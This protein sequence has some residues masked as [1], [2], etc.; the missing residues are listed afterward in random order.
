M[1]LERRSA[2]GRRSIAGRRGNV[3][4]I[5]LLIVVLLSLIGASLLSFG[6]NEHLI[7]FREKDSLS[8]FHAAEAG[9][10]RALYR[11]NLDP[12]L[13]PTEA[14]EDP[15]LQPN[16][17]QAGYWY[18]ASSVCPD[19]AT[20]S[21]SGPT[22]N[23]SGNYYG[24]TSAQSGNLDQAGC[25]FSGSFSGG[26][27]YQVRVVNIVRKNPPGP[28]GGW[29]FTDQAG[30]LE[31]N[32]R[33]LKITA[34]GTVNGRSRTV[35]AVVRKFY[36]ED[37]IPAPLTTNGDVTITGNATLEAGDVSTD[38]TIQAGGTVS[39]GGSASITNDGT[40][41]SPG[42]VSQNATFPGFQQI[43]GISMS[44]L[45]QQADTMV[46]LSANAT[47]PVASGLSGQIIWIDAYDES[48]G[49]DY[50]VTL[51]GGWTAGT[52][53][54]P[55]ILVVESTERLIVNTITVYGVIYVQGDVRSQG[56]A[57]ITGSVIVEGTAIADESFVAGTSTLVY[58]Q[59]VIDNLSKNG[60]AFDYKEVKGTWHER[61]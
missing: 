26:A 48:T 52:P 21:Y 58:Q 42:C 1:K 59:S 25:G 31:G 32:Y 17:T 27:T 7:S 6:F 18:G 34:T 28:G 36:L 53:D 8:A 3:L 23:G 46:T 16:P 14:I 13:F 30:A 10:Q 51:N 37:N 15:H 2:G 22:S 39:I 29:Q 41:C 11:I 19:N 9:R 20:W 57:N 56:G 24:A 45:K 61:S 4:V 55:V 47:N 49:S 5:T 60:G 54:K 12:L 44:E 50:T 40:P 33:Y 38:K 43:F 35:Q